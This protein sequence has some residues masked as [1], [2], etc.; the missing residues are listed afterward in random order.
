M[1]AESTSFQPQTQFYAYLF[2]SLHSSTFADKPF[3]ADFFGQSC[4][5]FIITL[6]VFYSKNMKS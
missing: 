1:T 2:M 6:Y 4:N 5:K 3:G